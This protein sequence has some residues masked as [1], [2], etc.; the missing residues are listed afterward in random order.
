M[1]YAGMLSYIYA[2]VDKND[3]RVASTLDWA[4]RHWNLEENVGTGKEGLY[5]YYNVL[6]KGLNAIGRD[7]LKPKDGESFNWRESVVKK[8]ISIQ[9]PE[10]DNAG[11]WVN[12]VGRYWESDPI[13]VTSYSLLALEYAIGL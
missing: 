6:A 9:K 5:Y 4:L 7:T 1:T 13:L 8:M 10:G 2:E 3:P 12:D 11:Y